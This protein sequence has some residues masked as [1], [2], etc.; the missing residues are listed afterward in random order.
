MMNN[1]R[2]KGFTLTELLV[3]LAIISVMVCLSQETLSLL[4]RQS[5]F[6][7]SSQILS[8]LA[9]A[10]S[11]AIKRHT[12]IGLCGLAKDH[13]CSNDWSKGYHAFV[14]SDVTPQALRYF[15]VPQNTTI[16]SGNQ[17]MIT[18]NFDGRCITRGTIYISQHEN[19]QKIVIYDSG[20]ARIAS[21]AS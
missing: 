21:Q 13:T 14:L 7:A 4:N 1:V 19:A 11:E 10:K 9:F 16:H 18:F 5:A 15:T 20:R 3:V 12:K 2:E 17:P 6:S 8:S